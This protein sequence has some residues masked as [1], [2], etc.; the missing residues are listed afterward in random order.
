MREVWISD[1]MEIC[2]VT[3]SKAEA[4]NERGVNPGTD[5]IHLFEHCWKE[6]SDFWSWTDSKTEA[7]NER[8]TN[9]SHDQKIYWFKHCP[10][11]QRFA[12]P[13]THSLNERGVKLGSDE[14]KKSNQNDRKDRVTQGVQC[15]FDIQSIFLFFPLNVNEF[16]WNF[17]KIN[18]IRKGQGHSS[19]AYVGKML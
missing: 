1:L 10:A 14:I 5:K 12:D 11:E 2:W 9:P 17:P 4:L 8:R 16:S 13:K 6:R 7:L 19:C 3:E 18:F 15:R